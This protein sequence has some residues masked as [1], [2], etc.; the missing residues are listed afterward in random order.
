MGD[1]ALAGIQ[2]SSPNAAFLL[3]RSI[4]RQAG[5]ARCHKWRAKGNCQ[6]K[7]AGYLRDKAGVDSEWRSVPNFQRVSQPSFSRPKE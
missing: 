3:M 1:A 5:L 2:F 6:S 4:Y 7:P